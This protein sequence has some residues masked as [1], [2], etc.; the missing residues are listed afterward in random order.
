[1]IDR[2]I[3]KNFKA[4]RDNEIDL[5]PLTLIVGPN[6]SGKTSILE[7]LHLV[8]QLK[9]YEPS[10]IP[11][12]ATYSGMITKGSKPP[13]PWTVEVEGNWSGTSKPD[14]IR[15]RLGKVGQDPGK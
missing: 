13:L 11:N 5:Q 6:A 1:M 15:L 9:S 8:S 2:V 3:F 10:K 7:G 4:L 12:P 14:K